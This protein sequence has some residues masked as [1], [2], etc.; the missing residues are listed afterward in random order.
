M[1]KI[2]FTTAII[3]IALSF[4][5]IAQ[6]GKK[7]NVIETKLI[8]VSPNSLQELMQTPGIKG[9]YAYIGLWA[10]WC[11]PCIREFRFKENVYELLAEYNNVVPIYIAIREKAPQ[12][13]EGN[14]AKHKLKGYNILA[15]ESLEKDMK[16][17]LEIS[18]D[19]IRIP[20]YFLIDPQGKVVHN[21][22]P[23]P[24]KSKELEPILKKELKK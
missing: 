20:R 7:N 22:L 1:K 17:K 4:G 14:V 9:N 13:W 19:V 8:E 12:G 3:A 11:P 23:R 6:S 10:S 21:N 18:G 24:S 2:L 16:E 15:S 5:V